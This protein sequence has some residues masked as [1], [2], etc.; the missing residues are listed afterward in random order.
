[1]ELHIDIVDYYLILVV[2][3]NM[4]ATKHQ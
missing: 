1:M 2:I 3:I 4:I